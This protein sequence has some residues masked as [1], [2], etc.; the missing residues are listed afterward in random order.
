MKTE[1]GG[2]KVTSEEVVTIEDL[3]ESLRASEIV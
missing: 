2:G 1:G 3:G